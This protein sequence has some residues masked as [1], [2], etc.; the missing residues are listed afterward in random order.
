[1]SI[2]SPRLTAS[3]LE[4]LLHPSSSASCHRVLT[5]FVEHLTGASITDAADLEADEEEIPKE[6]MDAIEK[7]RPLSS[8]KQVFE[9]DDCGWYSEPSFSSTQSQMIDS[10]SFEQKIWQGYCA[11][12]SCDG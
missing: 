2:C 6:L 9:G 1:M 4:L 10:H 3:V 12:W 5:A 8:V 7:Y 11:M